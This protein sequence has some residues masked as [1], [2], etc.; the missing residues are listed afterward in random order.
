M[1]RSLKHVAL[2]AL[3]ITFIGVSTTQS[4]AASPSKGTV[5]ANQLLLDLGGGGGEGANLPGIKWW[6][7]ETPKGNPFMFWSW[8]PTG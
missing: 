6:F 8:S 4:N 3:S 7:A 1:K 5:S 2:L